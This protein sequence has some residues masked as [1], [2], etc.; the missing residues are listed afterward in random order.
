MIEII[1]YKPEYKNLWDTFISSSRNGTFLF[2]RN[3]M[4][5]HSDKFKDNSFLIFKKGKIVGI[6]PGNIDNSI[7]YSHQG[8]TYGGIITSTKIETKDIIEIFRIFDNELMLIGIQEVIYKPIPL[9]YH[10]IPS[11]EDIYVL[12]LKKAE[13]IGCNISSTIFQN[14]KP[15]FTESRKSGL[16]KSMREGLEI[17]KSNGF[18]E[19][20][21]ILE[22][23]LSSKYGMKPVHSLAEMELLKNR[24]PENIE[25]YVAERNGTIVA[26]T[27]LYIMQNV[28]HVQYISASTAGKEFGALD[29]LF[30]KLINQIFQH[31]PVFDFG[32]STEKMGNYLNENLI[33][34]KE[35]FGGRGTVYEIYKYKLFNNDNCW[36]CIKSKLGIIT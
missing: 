4:D 32:T 35:G 6:I 18:R 10:K 33:F 19:F 23:N 5:Y 16:R 31:I 3:Y 2:Y 1:K 30:D 12:F 21:E 29:L 25:L 11:Q 13:R 15:C 7:Y 20:W 36:F 8:L 22:N 34:Q 26:G 28:V 9:I 14:A 24:F 17:N 27:V